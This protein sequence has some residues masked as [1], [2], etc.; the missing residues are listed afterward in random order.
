MSHD[1]DWQR[2]HSVYALSTTV[3]KI[4]QRQAVVVR[5]AFDSP[6]IGLATGEVIFIRC[7]T[8]CPSALNL[9]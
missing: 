3:A 1:A 5:V 9:R 2:E 6:R 4:T 7:D 8:Y